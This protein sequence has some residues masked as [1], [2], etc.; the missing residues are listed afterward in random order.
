MSV[1]DQHAQA[2]A[3][4]EVRAR[5]ERGACSF[6]E[7]KNTFNAILKSKR[8]EEY[9]HIIASLPDASPLSA[10]DELDRPM[11]TP[12][13]RI[14]RNRTFVTLIGEL[15]RTHKPWRM[16]ITTNVVTLIGES[17]LDLS[18]AEIPAN[19]VLNIVALIGETTIYIPH[20]LTV[21]IRSFNLIGECNFMGESRGGIINFCNEEYESAS[22]IRKH[23]VIHIL[24]LIGEIT[25]RHT[26]DIA[27]LAHHS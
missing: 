18:L 7:F 15:Q 5:Y 21:E 27:M 11:Q 9:A 3:L 2:E 24:T 20:S 19:G 10:L 14:P 1:P 8:P 13:K 12:R 16:G 4:R 26:D 6:D 17:Q 23:L 25:I 22:P